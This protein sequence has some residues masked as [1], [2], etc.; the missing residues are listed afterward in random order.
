MARARHVAVIGGGIIGCAT[1]LGLAK[2]G[3]QVTVLE[4]G[5]PGGESS[6]AA[7]GLLAPLGSA[8]DPS[9]FNRLAIESWRLY[10]EVV[11]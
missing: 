11:A 3:C 10:P 1:A 6:G 7:A 2:R 9:P 8:A 4:R 5:T